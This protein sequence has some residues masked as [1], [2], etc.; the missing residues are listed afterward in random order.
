MQHQMREAIEISKVAFDADD[1]T[2]HRAMGVTEFDFEQVF[3]D[4][5]EAAE[6]ISETPPTVRELAGELFRQVA[7]FCFR[8][9][10]PL[11]IATA[12]FAV[13]IAGLRPEV[14]GDRSLAEIGAELHLTKQ[15]M[16]NHSRKF[17]DAF[18]VR[19]Q[20]SRSFESREHMRAARL[21]GPCRNHGKERARNE[22]FTRSHHAA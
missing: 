16:S 11:R 21:G 20:R 6:L 8:G 19:F 10:K 7:A 2:H 5:D 1:P 3:K 18:K 14:L 4:L 13:I 12:K 17:S 9:D 15:S 22:A